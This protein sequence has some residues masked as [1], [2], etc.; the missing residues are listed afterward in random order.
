[1][2]VVCFNSNLTQSCVRTGFSASAH[3]RL[4]LPASCN[5]SPPPSPIAAFAFT[6]APFS[7]QAL[8]WALPLPLLPSPLSPSPCCQYDLYPLPPYPRMP[9]LPIKA[10]LPLLSRVESLTRNDFRI[11]ESIFSA[12]DILRLILI[13]NILIVE[14]HTNNSK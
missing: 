14:K 2:K 10:S 5:L 12:V 4:F 1:M 9:L 7:P 13:R 6:S 11:P 8:A 3:S